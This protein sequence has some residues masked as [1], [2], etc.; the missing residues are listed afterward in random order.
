[1]ST[2]AIEVFVGERPA[3]ELLDIS[4]NRCDAMR[5]SATEPAKDVLES[6]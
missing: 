1:M 5:R 2:V 6:M 3:Y 4:E